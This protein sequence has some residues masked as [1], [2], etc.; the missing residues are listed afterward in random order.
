M[1]LQLR[2]HYFRMLPPLLSNQINRNIWLSIAS[3][4]SKHINS[5]AK[6]HKKRIQLVTNYFVTK[7]SFAY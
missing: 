1:R 2:I 4:Y 5:F 6:L 3:I 7:L